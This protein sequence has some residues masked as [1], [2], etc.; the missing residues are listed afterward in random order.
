[1]KREVVCLDCAKETLELYEKIKNEPLEP[2][3]PTGEGL[4]AIEGK[5]NQDFICDRCNKGLP[6]CTTVMALSHYTDQTP[7]YVW[8]DEVLDR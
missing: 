2:G 1:M 7:Y 8:E 4:K 3:D 5:A 6:A